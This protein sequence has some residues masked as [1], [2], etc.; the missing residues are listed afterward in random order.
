MSNIPMNHSHVN[1]KP[2]RTGT[3][4]IYNEFGSLEIDKNANMILTGTVKNMAMALIKY[5][6][7]DQWDSHMT[8][9]EIDYALRIS[10]DSNGDFYLSCPR[11]D[12]PE[13]F[14]ELALEFDRIIKF[15][16]FW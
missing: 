3:T 15:K 11:E 14:D 5:M 16:A 10:L 1:F 8:S 7:I 2:L 6:I 13:F 12:K 4:I 9:Y